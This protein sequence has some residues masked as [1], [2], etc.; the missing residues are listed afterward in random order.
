[1]TSDRWREVQALF[2]AAQERPE[3]E[4]AA[5]VQ[6][7]CAGDADLRREVESLLAQPLSAAGF[8]DEAALALAAPLLSHMESQRLTG[9]RLGAYQIEG[10]IGAGGMGGVYRARD[11]K[12]GRDVAIKILPCAF[13][14]DPERLARFDREARVLAALNH[15]YIGA[16]Y[17]VEDLPDGTRALVLEL[18]DGPTLADRLARGPLP[19]KEAVAVATQVADALEAAHERGIRACGCCR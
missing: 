16:I 13:T 7:A 4:R 19:V 15:P 8:L 2:H 5:F 6:A 11:T 14:N 18:V 3:S 10:R 1:V 9:R 17:G 12:L